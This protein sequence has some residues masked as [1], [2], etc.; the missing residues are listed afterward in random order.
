MPAALLALRFELLTH[1]LRFD[2]ALELTRQML[3][4]ARA[5]GDREMEEDW[6]QFEELAHE[7]ANDPYNLARLD[8]LGALEEVDAVGEKGRTALM[9]AANAGNLAL[10]RRL[11]EEGADPNA[12]D[13]Y[14]WTPLLLAADEGHAEMI[15]LLVSRGAD[16]EAVTESG[17]TAL[18]L[19][20]WQN[21]LDAARALLELGVD[22]SATDQDGNTAL[23]LAATEPVPEM[24]RLLT[25]VVG[26]EAENE[27]TGGT[28]LMSAAASGL[29]ENLKIL[30]EL[31]ADPKTTDGEGD[32]AL[33]YARQHGREEAIMFLRGGN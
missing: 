24:L 25:P 30:L 17:Q 22:A 8:R 1:L 33:D 5:T 23:H 28:P 21:H 10:A 20:A 9:G 32:R 18:H 31:G 6:K 16:L 26:V 29:V 12:E 11:L 14:D 7:Q 2:E 3:Q 13:P 19:A 27:N 15:R 4:T